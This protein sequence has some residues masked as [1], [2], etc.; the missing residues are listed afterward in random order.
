MNQLTT[1]HPF[2]CDSFHLVSVAVYLADPVNID[3]DEN[4]SLRR[5][6]ALLRGKLSLFRAVNVFSTLFL[7]MLFEAKSLL[8]WR[9][10][11]SALKTWPTVSWGAIPCWMWL[12]LGPNS[13]LNFMY[14]FYVPVEFYAPR[15]L[16]NGGPAVG[17]GVHHQ[18][19]VV[20][21]NLEAAVW[22]QI[23][24]CGFSSTV[25]KSMHASQQS[26]TFCRNL[27]FCPLGS[28]WFAT[29]GWPTPCCRAKA[30]S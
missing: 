14:Q 19:R 13:N 8:S 15:C 24:Q 26:A 22:H 3:S 1:Y 10:Q 7:P 17:P 18:P 11:P 27:K 6:A 12:R 23:S 16:Q 4:N 30:V 28:K 5:Y 21:Q 20:G 25:W 2:T 9:Q 29:S